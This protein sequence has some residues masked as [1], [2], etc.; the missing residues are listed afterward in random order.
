[1]LAEGWRRRGEPARAVE[2]LVSDAERIASWEFAPR[3][4]L[5][6]EL[7]APEQAL[8]LIAAARARSDVWIDPV[9]QGRALQD[10]GRWDEARQRYEEA[11]EAPWF[12]EQA[13]VRLF[14]L[15]LARGP[16]AWAHGA[17]LALR[18]GEVGDPLARRRLALTRA[19]PGTPWDARDWSAL[20]ALAG[21]LLALAAAPLAWVLPLHYA[22]LRRGRADAPDFEGE[23]RWGARH[24]WYAGALLA[25][26]HFLGLYVFLYPDLQR[27]MGQGAAAAPA[28]DPVA[29]ARY[30]LAVGAMCALGA[31]LPLR[32]ADG[33]R[34]FGCRWGP[35]RTLVAC[36]STLVLLRV[37]AQVCM[38]VAD[39]SLATGASMTE[40][41]L[42]AL[43][44]QYG[45]AALLAY[46][47]A[48]VPLCEELL[49]R[50][51]MLGAASRFVGFGAANLFQALLFAA[52][53]ESTALAPFYFVVGLVCAELRRRSGGLRAPLLVHAG[54]NAI[55]IAGLL[56]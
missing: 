25:V 54:N 51:M 49:F 13:L 17:Y 37:I 41:M 15:A 44:E 48:L 19:F 24:L 1:V 34:V 32:R 16:A 47:V 39:G 10:S 4:E 3:V 38:R 53:H 50:G 5:L 33:R 6:V 27:W 21:T 30:G 14:E 43:H 40:G 36:A 52:L 42:R 2:A 45:A 46:A 11:A 7:G 9:L 26:V 35:A 8:A 23:R 31:L 18:D 29:L 12:R 28:R 55:A 56:F 20:G 22:A